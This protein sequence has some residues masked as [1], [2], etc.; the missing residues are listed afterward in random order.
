MV[1]YIMQSF[2]YT[3]QYDN[4]WNTNKLNKA[5]NKYKWNIEKKTKK[6]T[7]KNMRKHTEKHCFFVT[8]Y[9][10]CIRFIF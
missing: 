3:I 9:S 2:Y 10:K 8:S 4:Q 7:K 5:T 1:L 6:T